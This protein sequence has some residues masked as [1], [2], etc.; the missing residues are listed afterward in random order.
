M[1]MLVAIPQGLDPTALA[2]AGDNLALAV[3]CLAG[4]LRARPGARVLILGSRSIGLYATQLAVA[5][6]AGQVVYVDRDAEHRELARS[7]GAEVTDEPPNRDD[8]AFDVA[9]DAAM[10]EDWLRAVVQLLEPEGVVECP[11]I[12]FKES[13]SLPL[14]TMAIR[15]VHFHTG[16]GNVGPHIPRLLELTSAGTIAPAGITSE[17]LW[18]DTAPDALADPSWKPVF[19]RDA[20]RD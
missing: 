17:V 10:D 1:S 18:W 13:V 11:S 4:H 3:E 9:L 2:S 6:G 5:L 19:V 15:G 8:G 7:L 16:R 20:V 12:Y 14:F